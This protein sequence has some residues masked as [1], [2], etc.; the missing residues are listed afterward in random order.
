MSISS[1]RTRNPSNGHCHSLVKLCGLGSIIETLGQE[2]ADLYLEE[3]VSRLRAFA[4]SSDR[5]IEL[6][7]DKYCLVLT[8]VTDRSH[9]ELAAAK[10]E[11]MFE[12]P[13]DIIGERLDFELTAGF[14]VPGDRLV[15]PKLMLGAAETAL[16]LAEREQ[17]TCAI[18][19]A[20]ELDNTERPD[21][22]LLPKVERAIERGEFTLFYQPKVDCK[23]GQIVGAEGL[24]RWLDSTTN[25]IVPPFRFIEAVEGSNLIKPLTEQLV[26]LAVSR[27]TRWVAPLGVAVNVPPSLL[28]TGDLIEIVA[29][30]L[31]LQRLAPERLTLELTERGEFDRSAIARLEEIRA[32]GVRVA[33]DDFGTGVCSLSYFRDL[34]AD[35]I[36]IDQSFVKAMRESAKDRAIVECC[37]NLA[38]GCGM[39]VVAEGIEDEQTAEDLKGMGCDVL[40]GYWFG[41]PMHAEEFTRHHLNGLEAGA[42]EVDLASDLLD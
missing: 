14:V 4:R 39:E 37:I 22:G 13:A 23:Y 25:K 26:K 28:Q 36:K 19:S 5:L 16:R 42:E 7:Q 41:K 18:L 1:K 9:V 27:C 2:T 30:V 35:Q 6:S 29:D 20:E 17:S 40:Q 15:T 10:L 24:V 34:P 33:I 3:F 12:A 31:A 38:Q 11:R 32:L 21:P 8:G